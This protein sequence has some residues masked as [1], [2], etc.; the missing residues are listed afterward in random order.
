MH[1]LLL[2]GTLNIPHLPRLRDIAFVPYRMR[3]SAEIRIHKPLKSPLPTNEVEGVVIEHLKGQGI[4]DPRSV[5]SILGSMKQES[6]FRTTAHNVSEG[7]YGVFQWR[8]GRRERLEKYCKGDL[9]NI[10]CQ[11]RFAFQEKDWENVLPQLQE[12]G[13]S[14]PYYN[15]VMKKYLRWGELGF[16]LDYAKQY[17]EVFYKF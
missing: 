7:S 5:A 1:E 4:S 17:L 8:L 11:L 15:D 16:R 9:N 12:K 2:I 3:P 14:I 6:N 13:R 10:E